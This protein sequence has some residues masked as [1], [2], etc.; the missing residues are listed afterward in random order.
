MPAHLPE[1]SVTAFLAEHAGWLAEHAVTAR[2]TP[3]RDGDRLA[4]FDDRLTLHLRPG[5]RA[6][7][8]LSGAGLIVTRPEETD[9]LVPIER[10]YRTHARHELAALAE[11]WADRLGVRVGGIAI[12][13]PRGRWGSCS[14]RGRLSFSW[15]LMLAPRAVAE[16]VVA[17]EV[18][19]L[20]HL[21]HSPAFHAL[22]RR[23]DP[24]T[25]W[26]RA[27]LNDNGARLYAGPAWHV[28]SASGAGP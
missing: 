7:A 4:L 16:H 22:L 8:R 14:A 20:V 5:A 24:N 1:R 17:H 28:L 3:L 13:D 6:T 27:W 12:R 10:W 11:S 2:P 26:A 23:V 9:P 21:D 15:R 19:H 25:G 18:C